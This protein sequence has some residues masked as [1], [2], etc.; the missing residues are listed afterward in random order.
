MSY[1]RLGN[2]RIREK[3]VLDGKIV[4][5]KRNIFDKVNEIKRHLKVVLPEIRD[6]ELIGMLSRCR[7]YYE[8]VVKKG[9]GSVRLTCAYCGNTVEVFV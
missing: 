9:A 3:C 4:G 5:R 6:D 7:N 1:D 8:G 2:C